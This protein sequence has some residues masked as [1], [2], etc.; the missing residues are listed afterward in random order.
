MV[1][2]PE[3]LSIGIQQKNALTSLLNQPWAR[4]TCAVRLKR[5][6]RFF[7]GMESEKWTGVVIFLRHLDFSRS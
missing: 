2:P 3:R 7:S 6:L 4:G 5:Y 1:F